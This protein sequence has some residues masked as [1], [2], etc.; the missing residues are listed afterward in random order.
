MT[1]EKPQ[2]EKR[3]P[4]H[5]CKHMREISDN[6]LVDSQVAKHVAR[7]KGHFED[8]L[9]KVRHA[10]LAI[11]GQFDGNLKLHAVANGFESEIKA[12]RDKVN[13]SLK[14]HGSHASVVLGKIGAIKRAYGIE[15][16]KGKCKKLV[17]LSQEE[18]AA[19]GKQVADLTSS[20][21]LYR[22]HRDLILAASDGHALAHVNER[23]GKFV[24]V[25]KPQKKLG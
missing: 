16:R 4:E 9:N 3:I 5:F 8:S 1:H 18:Q 21:A 22:S 6:V 19:L 11:D 12:L 14:V 15:S 24:D 20:Y 25:L 7:S 10:R 13:D 23:L 17:P 2:H